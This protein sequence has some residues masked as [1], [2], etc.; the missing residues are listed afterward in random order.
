MRPAKRVLA[1][2]LR[3]L[4]ACLVLAAALATFGA[5]SA[6]AKECKLVQLAALP[7]SWTQEGRITVPVGI[8]GAQRHWLFDTGTPA[9]MIDYPTA[10]ELNLTRKRIFHGA[11]FVGS[12]ESASES[13]MIRELTIGNLVAHDVQVIV[14]PGRGPYGPQ[15]SGLLGADLL[16]NQDIELD[17][18]GAK[19]NIFSQEHCPGAVVY[20]P[21]NAVAIVPVRVITESGHIIVPVSLDGV[22]MDALLDTGASR[23]F[24]TLKAAH[25]RMNLSTRDLVES[26]EVFGRKAYKHTFKTLVLEG[27]TIKNPEVI[28]YSEQVSGKVKPEIGTRL[29]APVSGVEDMIL[30]MSQLRHL[31]IYIAYKEKKLYITAGGA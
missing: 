11:F 29:A 7:F 17:F 4:G 3:S 10:T 14:N 5:A 9:S 12:G 15:F 20:W 21:A 13:A 22:K 26:G 30:G 23:T 16:Q 25:D 31:R 2:S 24:L 1:P 19:L 27:I 8:E 6:P 18:K 28:L